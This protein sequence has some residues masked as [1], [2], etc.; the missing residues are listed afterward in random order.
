MF[1]RCAISS[2]IRV[3]ERGSLITECDN[4][5]GLRSLMPAR[6]VDCC[7]VAVGSRVGSGSSGWVLTGGFV[8]TSVAQVAAHG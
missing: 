4:G 6:A 1:D 8:T 2:R 5:L 3:A 7:A